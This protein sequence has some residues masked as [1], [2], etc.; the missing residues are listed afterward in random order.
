MLKKPH[1]YLTT[2]LLTGER[3]VGQTRGKMKYYKGGGIGLKRA[4][5]KFGKTNF[6]KKPIVYCEAEELDRIEE[7]FIAYY[8]TYNNGYNESPKAKGGNNPRARMTIAEKAAYS[9]KMSAAAIGRTGD[10]NNNFSGVYANEVVPACLE[11]GSI[12]GA[13]KKLG[14]SR[15]TIRRR[16]KELGVSAVYD[17]HPANGCITHFVSK[18]DKI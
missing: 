5:A 17:K 13:S 3:Y 1:I 10:K 7:A 9:R 6:V 4:F 18:G 11:A 12:L 15:K 16:L 2:N 14:V 8:D